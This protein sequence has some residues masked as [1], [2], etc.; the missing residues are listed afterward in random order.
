[1]YAD[2]ITRSMQ[3]TI[4][5]TRYRREKQMEYNRQHGITPTQIRKTTESV[6]KE[7]SRA[8]IE[9]EHVNMVADPV[10]AYMSKP[11]LEKCCKKQK[12]P[13]KKPL[14]RWTFWKPPAFGM[15]CSNW[16]KP[17]NDFIPKD[18]FFQHE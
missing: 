10:T 5:E 2:T 14:K 1:M 6:L 3:E 4:D 8:Y 18:L 15:K 7:T 13:C 16:K 17:L 12:R 11:E 9:E